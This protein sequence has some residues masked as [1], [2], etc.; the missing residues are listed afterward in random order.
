[1]YSEKQW[2]CEWL[3]EECLKCKKFYT[4]SEANKFADEI[5]DF[6]PLRVYYEEYYEGY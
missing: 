1:M 6:Y 4:E 2:V 3:A 5:W